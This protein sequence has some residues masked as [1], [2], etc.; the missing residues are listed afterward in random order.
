MLAAALVTA[1]GCGSDEESTTPVACLGPASTYLDALEAAPGDVRLDG[2]TPISDC[3]VAAQEGGPLAQVG[4]SAVGAAT[5]L[6]REIRGGVD[7]STAVQLGFLVGAIQEGASETGGIHEDL[8]LRLDAA[9]RFTGRREAFGARF[10]R[11]FGEGYAA[12]QD[13]G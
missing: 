12:G 13:H 3:V 4:E 5:R 2:T 6:N 9:A 10:E 8:V 1:A 11:A 7:Q